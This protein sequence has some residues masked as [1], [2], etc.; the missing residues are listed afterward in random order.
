[1]LHGFVT[2]VVTRNVKGLC[3]VK[4]LLTFILS[5]KFAELNIAA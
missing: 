4:G 2:Y 1:M 3:C 5:A